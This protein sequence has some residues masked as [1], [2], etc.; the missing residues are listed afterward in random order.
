MEKLERKVTDD[1]VEYAENYEKL[2]PPHSTFKY[3]RSPRE[4]RLLLK[5]DLAIVPL[6]AGCFFFAYLETVQDRTQIG[7]ARVMGLEVGLHISSSQYFNCL[8]MFFVGYMVFELPAALTLQRI[9]APLVFGT[10]VVL[11]GVAA[12]CIA[13]SHSYAPVMVLRVLTG[14][15]EA[16]VQTGNLYLAQWY[17]PN[18]VGTRAAFFYLPAP[19]AGAV[20]GLISYGVDRHLD[21]S[22]GISSWRWLFIVE[23]VPTIFWGLLVLVFLPKFPEAVAKHGS[24]I[25]REEEERDM[26][27]QRTKTARNVPGSSLKVAQIWLAIKDPK[28]W[29]QAM[30]VAAVC[31]NVAAFGVFLPTFIN[32]FGFSPLMTQLYTIIPYA[33]GIITLPI[34]N[35]LADHF[36][37]KGVPTLICLFICLIGYIMLLTSTTKAVLIVG[38]SFVAAGAY[39]AVVLSSA[40]VL[41]SHAGFTKRATAWAIAQIFIQCYSIISTQ[42][43]V[44]PPRFFEGHG[45][46]LG[47][48]ALGVVGVVITMWMFSHENKRRDAVAAEFAA[49]GELNPD[50]AKDYEELC[51]AHPDFRYTL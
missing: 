47:L 25:F 19:I 40:W 10:S 17:Y 29:L 9:P 12:C 13:A 14:A 42:V 39:P 27:L 20:G 30:A 18:E 48:N 11:F 5:Q 15:F 44:D 6:L 3:E 26:I 33:F 28:S 4:K 1:H 32:L 16:V 2:C 7:N 23:G 49:R 22:Q 51:D 8:M 35:I 24:W 45:T 21:G 50:S 31:L 37:K 36:D 38:C 41:I 46:L 34:G 43:Y